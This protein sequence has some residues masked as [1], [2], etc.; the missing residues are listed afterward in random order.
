MEEGE[1]EKFKFR[2]LLIYSGVLFI[3]QNGSIMVNTI[4]LYNLQGRILQMEVMSHKLK[5]LVNVTGLF[6]VI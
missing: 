1:E 4:P 3:H 2:I 5:I 6:A